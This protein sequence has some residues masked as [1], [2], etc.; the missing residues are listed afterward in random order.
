[1]KFIQD[2]PEHHF[3]TFL[4]KIKKDPGGWMGYHFALSK[5]LSHS[6]IISKPDHIKGKLH[7]LGQECDEVIKDLSAKLSD[8]STAMLYRFSDC[9][10]IL[11][12]RPSKDSEREEAMM[13]YNELADKIGKKLCEHNNLAKDLYSY[14]KLADQRFLSESRMKAY[15]ALADSNRVQSIPLRRQR[16]EDAVIL[17]VEDD[18]FT[19]SYAANI[20][21]KEFDIVLAKTGEEAISY[22]VEHAP[23]MVLLDI[24]LPG[25]DGL[26]TLRGLR[27]IDKDAFIF[28]LSVDTVKQNIIQAQQEGAAGFLKKPFGK[29]RLMAAVNQS[30]FIKELKQKSS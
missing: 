30:P 18:R 20:L 6:E 24:H 15:E 25:L 14:Q 13:L 4:D 9:D 17:I 28:M 22:Y 26:D 19:A 2:S 7:K 1:M 27:K 23:D 5:K 12:R 11:L 10:V 21:N 16:R 3:L 8:D 29:E